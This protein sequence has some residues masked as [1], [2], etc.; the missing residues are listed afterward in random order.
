[1]VLGGPAAHVSSP[2][3][4]WCVFEVRIQRPKVDTGS[5]LVVSSAARGLSHGSRRVEQPQMG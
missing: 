1:M 3:V 4:A 2:N 5:A